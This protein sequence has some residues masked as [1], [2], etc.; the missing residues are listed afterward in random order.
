[1]W[2]QKTPSS[3]SHGPTIFN[4]QTQEQSNINLKLG[5]W[6][7]MLWLLLVLSITMTEIRESGLLLVT[8]SAKLT[9]LCKNVDV[10]FLQISASQ[11]WAVDFHF[12]Q[13]HHKL[14]SE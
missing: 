11:Q 9:F 8:L 1:M 13:N 6:T 3:K 4:S 5:T 7:R 2:L 10:T 12:I 14:C